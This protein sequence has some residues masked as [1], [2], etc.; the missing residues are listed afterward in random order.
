MAEKNMYHVPKAYIKS[1][2]GINVQFTGITRF[3]EDY[4]KTLMYNSISGENGLFK[5]NIGHPPPSKV[6]KEQKNLYFEQLQQIKNLQ[7]LDPEVKE[8]H[9]CG[10]MR[11]CL[12]SSG[13]HSQCPCVHAQAE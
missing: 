6:S 11:L 3:K 4:N 7:Y 5:G 2:N 8:N 12:K 1:A 10:C 9:L 13:E